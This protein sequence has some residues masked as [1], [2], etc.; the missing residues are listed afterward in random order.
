MG[1]CQNSGPFLGTLNN[2]CHTITGTQK[3]TII[4][5][6]HHIRVPYFR[7]PPKC[8]RVRAPRGSQGA[9]QVLLGVE[10]TIGAFIIRIGF[11]SGIL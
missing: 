11:L 5:R 4:L 9:V 3:R 6:T 2:R 1:G 7:K 8:C 10:H